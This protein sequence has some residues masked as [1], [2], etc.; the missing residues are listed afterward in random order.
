[1]AE[2]VDL[3]KAVEM[4]LRIDREVFVRRVQRTQM[5]VTKTLAQLKEQ[6][7]REHK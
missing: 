2:E 3:E 6:R 5:N 4:E 7:K 1:V